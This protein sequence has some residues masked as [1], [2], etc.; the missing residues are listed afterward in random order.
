MLVM[1]EVVRTGN[2][3][4]S[5]SVLQLFV[6]VNKDPNNITWIIENLEIRFIVLNFT[7]LFLSHYFF[8][9]LKHATVL[10]IFAFRSVFFFSMHVW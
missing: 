10:S 1:V 9:S 8:R 7:D 4:A 2:S 6:R 3:L 5:T